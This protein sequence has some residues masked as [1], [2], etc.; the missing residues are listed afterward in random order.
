MNQWQR[1]AW[2]N[3]STAP[4]RR[5]A[6]TSMLL[7]SL[8]CSDASNGLARET[9]FPCTLEFAPT[10]VMIRSDEQGRWPD[11]RQPVVRDSRGLFYSNSSSP[12]SLAIWSPNGQF[13]RTLG[14]LGE[15]PGEFRRS[16]GLGLWIIEGDTLLVRDNGF[17]WSFFGPDHEY[18]R[19]FREVGFVGVNR[20]V[21]LLDDGRFA[22][23][24]LNRLGPEPIPAMRIV[25]RTGQIEGEV[26]P[27]DSVRRGSIMRSSSYAGGTAVWLSPP[28]DSVGPYTLEEWRLDN[29]PLRRIERV[30][31][32]YRVTDGPAPDGGTMYPSVR[33][34]SVDSLGLLLVVTAL[35]RPGLR[36]GT[37]SL[38]L[39][40][41]GY[42]AQ[43]RME[44]IDPDARAVIASQEV[45]SG[46]FPTLFPGGTRSGYR[47]LEDS[48]GLEHFEIVRW[49]LRGPAAV[50]GEQAGS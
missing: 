27:L 34:V 12:G 21:H 31:S 38:P 35:Q 4:I 9:D 8:A 1:Q 50:C 26:G 14:R 47:K 23:S 32:W 24:H 19:R 16:G 20:Y 49:Q 10:G 37:D 48:T 15:G 46:E 40:L 36:P 7:W 44:V 6:V 11:P 39:Q 18:V 5:I 17:Q 29:K 3:L 28:Y 25:S 43:L 45:V 42:P 30:A 13:L 2:G 41:R 33:S 22:G